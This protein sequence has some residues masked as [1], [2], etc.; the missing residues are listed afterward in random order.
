MS[1]YA[2][3]SDPDPTNQVKM[4]VFETKKE[5]NKKRSPSF[6]V[7]KKFLQMLTCALLALAIPTLISAIS[8]G[9]YNWF[10]CLLA[11]NHEAVQFDLC[12]C[13]C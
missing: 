7:R 4:N 9:T 6:K 2:V 3:I 8:S 12:F 13:K 5:K 1:F 11:A 10:N